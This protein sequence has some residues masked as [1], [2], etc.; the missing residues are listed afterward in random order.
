ML[1]IKLDRVSPM[2]VPLMA[3]I[4][5]ESVAKGSVDDALLVEA[6]SLAGIAMTP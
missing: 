4:G 6:E 1:H 3:M 2:A 5:R